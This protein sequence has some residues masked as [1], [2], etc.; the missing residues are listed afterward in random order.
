[1]HYKKL[2][3]NGVT[4]VLAVSL[5]ASGVSVE[6]NAKNIEKAPVSQL[7]QKSGGKP[8]RRHNPF[9]GS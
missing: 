6:V 7:V 9:R 4:C 1:M 2:L 3:K 8:S 5:F